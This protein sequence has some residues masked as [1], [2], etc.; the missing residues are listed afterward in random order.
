MFP[1]F[2]WNWAAE[3]L[4]VALVYPL[5]VA[6]GAGTVAKGWWS[7][8]CVFL[9]RLSY[10]LYMTHYAAIWMFGGYFTKY[11]PGGWHLFAI[12]SIGT[13]ILIA[14]SYL[15]MR[16]FDE[17]VRAYLNRKRVQAGNADKA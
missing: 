14:F 9:G 13:L 17:P 5:I 7:K 15:V 8:C 16:F 4:V 6:L 10:P 1:W 3:V 2:S 11:K 12:I